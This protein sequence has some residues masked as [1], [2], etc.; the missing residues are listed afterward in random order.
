MREAF[1]LNQDLWTGAREHAGL[2]AVWVY[3][4]EKTETPQFARIEKAMQTLMKKASAK[5]S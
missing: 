4:G 1:R 3:T 2:E 5:P